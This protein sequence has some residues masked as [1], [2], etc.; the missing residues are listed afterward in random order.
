MGC[1]ISKTSSPLHPL[2][3]HPPDSGAMGPGPS[4]P[5]ASPASSSAEFLSARASS[6]TSSG[7][8][9]PMA[10]RTAVLRWPNGATSDGRLLF[11]GEGRAIFHAARGDD[12]FAAR[13]GKPERAGRG[14]TDS[15]PIEVAVTST[16]DDGGATHVEPALL[17]ALPGIYPN[18]LEDLAETAGGLPGG[19]DTRDAVV[20]SHVM[21][22]VLRHI[23]QDSTDPLAVRRAFDALDRPFI[24]ISFDAVEQP[25][26]AAHA[27]R[28]EVIEPERRY[29]E[30]EHDLREMLHALAPGEH[31]LLRGTQSRGETAH[32]LA[33]SITRLDGGLVQANLL[34]PNGW[35]GVARRG[36]LHHHPAIG[37]VL[38]LEQA[39]AALASLSGQVIE[40]PTAFRSS[41]ALANWHQAA[42]GAPFAAWLRAVG[43][44][45]IL[46]PTG[47]RMTPQKGADCVVELQFAWLASVLPEA[48]YKL[49]KA[50]VLNILAEA[51]TANDLDEVVVE[52]LRQ[53]VTSSLSGHAMAMSD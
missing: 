21:Q 44:E 19:L 14:E 48:D 51:A 15:G 8:G 37:K 53:R 17:Q 2:Q 7:A 26:G 23:E 33:I 11:N 40:P 6:P 45:S 36:H 4:R 3:A 32:A 52:R 42:N 30:P 29:G 20:L 34:N 50:Q 38:P 35:G 13:C 47:Q 1:T 46:Q 16:S 41:A 24:E 12:T 9:S 43:P 49:A 27:Y 18:H 25:D 31:L 10:P 28:C 5:Q 39:G 22:G